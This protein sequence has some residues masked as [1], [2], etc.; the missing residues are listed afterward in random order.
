MPGQKLEQIERVYSIAQALDQADEFL[1]SRSWQVLTSYNTAGAAKAIADKSEMG[2]AALASPR[3]PPAARDRSRRAARTARTS[4]RLPVASLP[5]SC[6]PSCFV[7]R[8]YRLPSSWSA[9]SGSPCFFATNYSLSSL[10]TRA[11][12]RRSGRGIRDY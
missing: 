8:C 6:P 1:R 4:T 12:E 10:R 11:A 3:E 2:S 5:W 9:P 7:Y